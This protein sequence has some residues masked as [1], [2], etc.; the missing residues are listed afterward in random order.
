MRFLVPLAFLAILAAGCT[1]PCQELGSRLCEC[2]TVTTTDT[3]E[4]QVDAQLDER[5]PGNDRCETWLDTCRA[6]EGVAFCDW[7]QTTA[8]KA[9]CGLAIDAP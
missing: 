5:N 1:G 8:A 6:P 9:R 7:L 4:R 3:C 2:A